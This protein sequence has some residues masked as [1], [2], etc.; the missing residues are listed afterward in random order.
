MTEADNADAAGANLHWRALESLY[1]SAAINE[2][3]RS[4]LQITGEGLSCITFDVGP[5]C[6]HAAGAAHGTIYFKMLDDAAFYAANTLITDRFLLTTS[7]NLLLSKPI[8]GGTVR[9][10]GRWVSG[11]RRV[12]V[13]ESRLIDEEGDEV[14][15]GT[16]TFMRSRIPLSGLPGYSAA[17][18]AQG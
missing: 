12:L 1:A 4:A 16:G 5:D 14:G 10:E 9:A 7:F 3:F 13:A 15:R 17:F 6:F 18:T 11:R 2:K 8:K